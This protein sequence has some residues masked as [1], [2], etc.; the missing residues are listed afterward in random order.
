[1]KN[2]PPGSRDAGGGWSSARLS[3]AAA[4]AASSTG[5]HGALAEGGSRSGPA[6]GTAGPPSASEGHHARAEGGASQAPGSQALEGDAFGVQ[7][8]SHDES[9]SQAVARQAIAASAQHSAG[10][11]AHA[12]RH[13]RTSG[14]AA[15]SASDRASQE[16]SRDREAMDVPSAGGD[17]EVS[18]RRKSGRTPDSCGARPL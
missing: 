3:F 9:S 6:P 15:A 11:S 10:T 12:M 8:V 5:T 13:Q 2:P 4:G 18:S 1:M 14:S 17:A 7:A 16:R